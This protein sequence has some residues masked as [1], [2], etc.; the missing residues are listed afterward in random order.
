M[1]NNICAVASEKEPFDIG[2]KVYLDA[3]RL[4]YSGNFRQSLINCI[5]SVECEITQPVENWLQ[6]QTFTKDPSI[7]KTATRELSNP[8]RFEIFINSVNSGAFARYND[9]EKK[10][11]ITKFRAS[12]TIRNKIVHEGYYPTTIETKNSV[13]TSGLFLR[14]LWLHGHGQ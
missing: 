7:V 5:T 4:F 11:L 3:I 12:N 14:A 2:W 10:E 8:L 6:N 1:Q 9:N 13:E